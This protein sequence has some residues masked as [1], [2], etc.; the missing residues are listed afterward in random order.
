MINKTFYAIYDAEKNGWL[1]ID[2]KTWS[3]Y[4]TPICLAE[5]HINI[6][7]LRDNFGGEIK[8]FS[9]SQVD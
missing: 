8:T 1:N 2:G 3:K 5:S 4:L 6:L 7:F 9:L